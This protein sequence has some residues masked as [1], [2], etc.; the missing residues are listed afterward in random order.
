MSAETCPECGSALEVRDVPDPEN[1]VILFHSNIKENV[2]EVQQELSKCGVKCTARYIDLTDYGISFRFA[3]TWA[4]LA[5]KEDVSAT[6][7]R[8]H[9]MYGFEPGRK[10]AETVAARYPSMSE[11]AETLALKQNWPLVITALRDPELPGPLVERAINALAL[12][13][14]PA[15]ETV[16]QALIEELHKQ[17]YIVG[18]YVIDPLADVLTD[19]GSEKATSRLIELLSDPDSTTRINAI[20]C[21]GIL[22]NE[23]DI[24]ALLPLL[25]D[26]DAD[27]RQEANSA[28]GSITDDSVSPEYVETPE[29]GREA[30]VAWEQYLADSDDEDDDDEDEEDEDGNGED[31]E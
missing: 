27:V 1:W 21:L 23:E 11:S 5:P 9:N 30:R 6:L 31:E 4:L 8:L 24:A 26:E 20:H 2:L 17:H 16:L 10:D 7:D 25:E 14:S 28:I 22:G 3:S 19:I 18:S 29:E 12:A 13:G 15:E